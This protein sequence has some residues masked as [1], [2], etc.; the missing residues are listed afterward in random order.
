MAGVGDG[1]AAGNA[2]WSFGGAV[3]EHFDE[4]V[5][6]SVPLY[7]E[8]HALTCALSDFFVKPGST[9]YEIGCSTGSL[10]LSLA[11]HNAAK[12]AARFV[13][14]DVMPEMVAVAERKRAKLGLPNVSFVAD[15]ALALELEPADLVVAYYTVQFVRPSQR[16]QLIDKVFQTLQW[17]GGF[18]LFEKVRGPDARFQDM[19][20]TLYNDYKLEQGYTPDEIVSKTRSLKGVLEPFSTQGNLDLLRRAGFVD[21]TT[22]MKY[23]CFEG[24]LAI[25]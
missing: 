13:G 25:K 20:T 2:S 1:L 6:K 22:V 18:L 23:L 16:Q 8:G 3:A 14:I 17:G 9:V 5:S 24:F 4:H 12:A 11:R 21:V 19:L 7:R 15:D 10:T